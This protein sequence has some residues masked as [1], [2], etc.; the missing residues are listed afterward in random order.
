MEEDGKQVAFID[1]T[2]CKGCGGCVPFC[3][4]ATPSISR[5]TPTPRSRAMIDGLLARLARPVVTQE[6]KG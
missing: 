5:A 1:K 3:P 2:A 6:V 4:K